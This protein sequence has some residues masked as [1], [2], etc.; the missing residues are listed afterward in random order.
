MSVTGPQREMSARQRGPPSPPTN[1]T[2][3]AIRGSGAAPYPPRSTR[4]PGTM[5]SDP[6]GQRTHAL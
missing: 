5:S 4:D 6:S 1:R 3:A 2:A